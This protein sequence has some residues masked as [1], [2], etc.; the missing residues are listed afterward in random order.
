[1]NPPPA[2]TPAKHLIIAGTTR[3]GTTSLYNYFSD[4]PGI[5][6]STIKETRFFMDSDELRRLHRYEDGPG[7]YDKFFPGCPDGAVRLEATP[8]YLY[9]PAA[10]TRIAETLPQAHVV[11]ILREPISRLISWRR[12]AIQNGLLDQAVTLGDFIRGQFDAIEN[13]A[14]DQQ[15]QHLRSLQEGRYS[16]YLEPWVKTFSRD[17]LTVIPYS[18]LLSN[19]ADVARR[20]CERVGIEPGFYDGYDFAIHNESRPVRWPRVHAAY[21]SLIWRI[22]AHVHD[23]PTARAV[24]R[25]VRRGTDTALGRAGQTKAA[26]PADRQGDELSA[27]DRQRLET[28]YQQEP[29]ELARLLGLDD[30]HW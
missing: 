6:A 9:C 28:Y 4:H 27:R 15:P 10:A 23:K 12:Y 29:A 22:K 2:T 14:A 26:P 7:D 3:A 11:V 8:D 19:P 18:D 16:N 20:L 5:C 17:Q 13:N 21:R 25:K 30:W 24:L 1:M